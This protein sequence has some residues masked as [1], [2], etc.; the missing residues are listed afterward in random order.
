MDAL[1]GFGWVLL[2]CS[3]IGLV[4]F[5]V[6]ILARVIVEGV[7]EVRRRGEDGKVRWLPGLFA[8][9]PV[10]DRPRAR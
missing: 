6:C 2:S 1:A 10:H 3:V 9:M 5:V 4:G 7:S 8:A